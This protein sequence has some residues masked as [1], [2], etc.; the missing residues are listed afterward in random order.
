MDFSQSCS[1]AEQSIIKYKDAP[2][3]PTKG[4]AQGV[5][6]DLFSV[7]LFFFLM[8]VEEESIVNWRYTFSHGS[9]WNTN[10]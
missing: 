2:R 7:L 1:V 4:L 6:L 9:T 3:E 8:L 10:S 5:F